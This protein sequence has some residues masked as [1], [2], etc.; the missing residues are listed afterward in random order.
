MDA[1]KVRRTN[2]PTL[3]VLSCPDKQ[4]QNS[5]KYRSPIERV[6]TGKWD[7]CVGS[8]YSQKLNILFVNNN[9]EKSKLILLLDK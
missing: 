6:K 7:N 8:F 4:S 9:S 3:T 5:T 2:K 1:K